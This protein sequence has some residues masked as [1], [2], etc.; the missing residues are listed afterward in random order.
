MHQIQK[1]SI[2]MSEYRHIYQLIEAVFNLDG[3]RELCMEVKLDTGID[4]QYE[5]LAGDTIRRKAQEL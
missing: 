3:I 1:E 2:C 4:L 5:N